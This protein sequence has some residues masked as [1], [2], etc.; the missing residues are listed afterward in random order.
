MKLFTERQLMEAYEHARL[1]G[2]ALHI[3]SDPSIYPDC[4][5]CFKKSRE[6]AHLFDYDIRRLI[7]TAKKLGVHVIRIGR[8]NSAASIL[9][10]VASPCS[11]PKNRPCRIPYITK[12][13]LCQLAKSLVYCICPAL[14]IR[15]NKRR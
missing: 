13:I 1:G 6:A 11:E 7:K 5:N 8:R 3:F 2:Q 12:Q 4:P 14:R 10:C 9:I 15:L